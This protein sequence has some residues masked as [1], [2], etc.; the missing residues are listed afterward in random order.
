M[1]FNNKENNNNNHL[2]KEYK[3]NL[4]V[5]KDINHKNSKWLENSI[6]NKIDYFDI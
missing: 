1:S 4:V 5:R 2:G 3:L 6:E